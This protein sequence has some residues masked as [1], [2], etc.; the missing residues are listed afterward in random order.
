[1]FGQKAA[2]HLCLFGVLFSGL[3]F[4]LLG[5]RISPQKPSVFKAGL[6][7]KVQA[8]QQLFKNIICTKIPGIL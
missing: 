2:L 4:F 8:K 1:M 6:R 5:L 7:K 3:L